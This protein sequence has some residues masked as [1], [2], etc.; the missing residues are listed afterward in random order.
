[1]HLALAGQSI[2][3]SSWRRRRVQLLA[4]N[5]H[6]YC[7]GRIDRDELQGMKE[8]LPIAAAYSTFFFQ[9]SAGSWIHMMDLMAY[10]TGHRLINVAVLGGVFGRKALNPVSSFGAAVHEERHA[11]D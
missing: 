7:G 11:I 3:L 4:T 6:A 9:R 2:P 10:R 1:M 8:G 5:K